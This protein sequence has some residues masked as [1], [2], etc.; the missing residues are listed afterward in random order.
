MAGRAGQDDD[1]GP[2]RPDGVE[3]GVVPVAL[4]D[5]GD[6]AVRL[7]RPH[8]L[9]PAAGYGVDHDDPGAACSH[10]CHP[11]VRHCGTLRP[12]GLASALDH[13]T[14]PRRRSTAARRMASPN[15]SLTM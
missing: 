5:D 10:L 3:G 2:Q 6:V 15:D 12:V 7:Q 11:P 9:G 13:G 4:A 14:R 8:Q 1:I